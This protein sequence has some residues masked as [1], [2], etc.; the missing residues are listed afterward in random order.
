[1]M[2]ATTS[3]IVIPGPLPSAPPIAISSSVSAVNRNAVLKVFMAL[4]LGACSGGACLYVLTAEHHFATLRVRVGNHGVARADFALE[5]LQ[6]ERILNQALDCPL[7]RPRAVRWIVAFAEEQRLCRGSEFHFHLPLSEPLHQVLQL[8]VN[9]A[10]D[11]LL[12][13][14]MEDHD[15]VNAVQE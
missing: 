14:R 12:P 7:H 10:F 3:A 13:E 9:D 5:H 4:F 6:S 1:M 15:V 11:L 2:M 8:Q